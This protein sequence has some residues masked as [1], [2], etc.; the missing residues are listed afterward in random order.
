MLGGREVTGAEG[1]RSMR[2]LKLFCHLA[3]CAGQ[4]TDWQA[5]WWAQ[6]RAQGT[7]S[8]DASSIGQVTSSTHLS[9]TLERAENWIH[10]GF[11]VGWVRARNKKEARESGIL[12]GWWMDFV[13]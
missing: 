6:S 9:A 3:E 2:R 8:E 12:V 5:V 7:C 4:K 11:S 10:S 13:V 1:L